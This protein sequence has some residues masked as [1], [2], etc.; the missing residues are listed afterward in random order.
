MQAHA[1]APHNVPNAAAVAKATN[2]ILR[3]FRTYSPYWPE[4]VAICTL[5]S[6]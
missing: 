2:A 3:K 6:L 4:R 5:R 1:T